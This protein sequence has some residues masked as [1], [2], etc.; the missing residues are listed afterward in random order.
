MS[1]RCLESQVPVDFEA[2]AFLGGKPSNG[3]DSA[4]QEISGFECQGKVTYP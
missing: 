4:P 3:R 1:A 2:D